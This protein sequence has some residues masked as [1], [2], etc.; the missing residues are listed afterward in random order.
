L[1]SDAENV[2]EEV[3]FQNLQKKM[4]KDHG[5]RIIT[6]VDHFFSCS[7]PL[8]FRFRIARKIKEINKRLDKIAAD[9][10][11]FGFQII[12]IHND[13]HVVMNRREM[14]YSRV[15]NSEVIGREN[16]KKNIIKLLVQHDNDKNLSV[17]PIAGLGGLGKTTLAKLVFNDVKIDECFTIK[18]WVC[19][20]NSFDIKE[21]IIKI[22][23]AAP[24]GDAPAYQQSYRDL[25][26]E[27]LQNH[28]RQ[29]VE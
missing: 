24:K 22:I 6:K 20:S 16:D 5:S 4:I 11:K 23:N 3:D 26:I 8:A 19:V 18:M 9:R 2:L 7:N 10:S 15:I 29:R 28:L 21:V 1:S 12:D 13:T 25:D 14:T 27:Q 17:I